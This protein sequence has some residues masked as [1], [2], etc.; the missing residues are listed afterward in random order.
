[1]RAREVPDDAIYVRGAVAMAKS[2][3]LR[4]AVEHSLRQT[5]AIRQHYTHWHH[6][7]PSPFLD[8]MP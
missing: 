5:D 7:P 2:E 4:Q 1:M 3:H 8:R 6:H